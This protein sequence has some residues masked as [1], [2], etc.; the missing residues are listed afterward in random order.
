MLVTDCLS[1]KVGCVLLIIVVSLLPHAAWAMRKNGRNR[2]HPDSGKRTPLY[3]LGSVINTKISSMTIFICGKIRNLRVLGC[4]TDFLFILLFSG[5][6]GF[7]EMWKLN[8]D[9]ER[10]LQY[11]EN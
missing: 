9:L 5:C 7:A 2:D 11:T 6:I 4:N 1:G 10:K 3:Y 8:S